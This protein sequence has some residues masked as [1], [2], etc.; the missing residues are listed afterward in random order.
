MCEKVHAFYKEVGLGVCFL[1][2][3]KLTGQSAGCVLLST[4]KGENTKI[5][6]ALDMTVGPILSQNHKTFICPLRSHYS[7]LVGQISQRQSTI[8]EAELIQHLKYTTSFFE[9]I[10]TKTSKLTLTKQIHKM[11][12]Y[13]Q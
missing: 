4:F 5:Y 3:E 12:F 7:S 8:L 10:T 6:G 11:K 1:V 13:L 2:A 9:T